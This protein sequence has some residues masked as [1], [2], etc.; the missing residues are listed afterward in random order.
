MAL[1]LFLKLV[2][3]VL[4]PMLILHFHSCFASK[5]GS[6][7]R[8]NR[9]LH[10][11]LVKGMPPSNQVREALFHFAE[12]P[13]AEPEEEG[14][15]GDAD[16]EG[17]PVEGGLAAEEAPAETVND[18]NHRVQR[19]EET[20]L[21]G[22][23]TG[24]EADRRDVEA[25]LDDEWDDESKVAVFDIQRGK[26]ETRPEGGQEGEENKDREEEE[27]P[28]G[29]E[30]VVDHHAGDDGEADQEINE[31]DDHSGGGDNE[32]R[33]V[34]LAD[35]VG[36]ADE[37]V[38]GLG[39]GGGEE[40]PRQHAGKD[41][42][43]VRRSAFGG[44]FRDF[45]KDDG[46]DHHGEEGADHGPKNADDGLFVADRDI[47]PSK[48]GEE[49]P[50]VPEVSPVIFFGAAIFEDGFHGALGSRESKVEEGV[51]GRGRGRRPEA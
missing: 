50:V 43:G 27:L 39:Q 41:H 35:E 18:A 19:V 14:C 44:E 24:T 40:G 23:D 7:L 38:G 26:P 47:P 8:V 29:Q 2:G 12:L 30:P 48:D 20:V 28:A 32:P 22:D 34:N 6:C 51:E 36:I 42:Q 10:Q 4:S 25:E 33:E 45:P 17:G 11:T 9:G 49:L 5:T 31:R 15:D 16:A 37:A 3:S 13:D 21:L 1:L 46:E